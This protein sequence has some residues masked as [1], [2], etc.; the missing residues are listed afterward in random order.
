LFKN[1]SQFP[2]ILIGLEMGI[3]CDSYLLLFVCAHS[4]A[5]VIFLL[6]TGTYGLPHLYMNRDDRIFFTFPYT[7][8]PPMLPIAIISI[9]HYAHTCSSMAKCR[10]TS[11]IQ[12][13]ISGVQQGSGTQ[14]QIPSDIVKDCLCSKSKKKCG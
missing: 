3:R 10:V 11:T 1:S 8:Y 7:L 12:I 2:Q 14:L 4:C 13:A 9:Q 6:Y 5:L